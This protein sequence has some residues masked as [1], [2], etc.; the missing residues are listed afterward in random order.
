MSGSFTIMEVMS[1]EVCLIRHAESVMQLKSHLIGGRSNWAPITELGEQQSDFLGTYLGN[2]GM[3]PDRVL[4]SPAV[5]TRQTAERSLA[6]MGLGLEIEIHDGLQEMD[7]GEWEGRLRDEMLTPDALE[8]IV[9]M[10]KN[11]RPP[12]GESMNDVGRRLYATLDE[13]VVR[14]EMDGV[15]HVYTHGVAIRSL[16]SLLY[17]WSRQQTFDAVTDNTSI[18]TLNFDG[19]WELTE[20]ARIPR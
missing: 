14:S 1:T 7:Q 13:Q 3:K 6:A 16:V 9:A 8:R 5:R 19:H 20:F 17:G 15:I 10:G 2:E 12:G 18:T 4:S 11:A